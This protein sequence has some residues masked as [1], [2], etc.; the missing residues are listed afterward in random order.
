MALEVHTRDPVAKIV[1]RAVLANATAH[2]GDEMIMFHGSSLLDAL[3]SIVGSGC[4]P[5]QLGLLRSSLAAV[6]VRNVSASPAP[7]E[8]CIFLFPIRFR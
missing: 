2:D 5:D 3:V 6:V 7:Y 4:D 1:W 8:V